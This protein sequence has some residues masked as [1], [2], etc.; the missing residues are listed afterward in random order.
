M[1]RTGRFF[2][3]LALVASLGLTAGC[4]QSAEISDDELISAIGD[5][6]TQWLTDLRGPASAPLDCPSSV[7]GSFVSSTS[8][9]ARGCLWTVDNTTV[10]LRVQNLTQV[11]LTINFAFTWYTLRPGATQDYIL[12]KPRYNQ[13]VSFSRDL[14]TAA[15]SAILDYA[16]GQQSPAT[17]WASC[18]EG[19]SVE[20][21]L[22][23]LEKLLPKEVTIHGTVVPAQRIVE[24]AHGV[25]T[26]AP[27]VAAFNR[28]AQGLNQGTLTFKSLCQLLEVC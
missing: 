16:K 3:A 13:T 21:I 12:A 26:Y 15:G 8:G 5:W 9:E 25:W 6:A 18:V 11:P 4:T 7:P 24:V 17:Q 20:C 22:T 14:R 2:A 19:L 23:G 27:L 28:Q 10:Y 1:K